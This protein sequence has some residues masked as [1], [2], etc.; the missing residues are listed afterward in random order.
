[1]NATDARPTDEQLGNALAR[2]VDR[3]L[4]DE[5]GKVEDWTRE[6]WCAGD[7]PGLPALAARIGV[8]L[9][10]LIDVFAEEVFSETGQIIERRGTLQ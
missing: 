2:A 5:G 7:A 9:D 1:M 6:K 4:E 3:I 10:L 8:P